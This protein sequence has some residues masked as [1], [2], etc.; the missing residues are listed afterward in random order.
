MPSNESKQ[1]K[2]I[3]KEGNPKAVEFRSDSPELANNNT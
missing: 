1:G 2:A 3:K